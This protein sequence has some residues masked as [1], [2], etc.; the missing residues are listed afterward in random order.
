M[1]VSISKAAEMVGVTRAT[2]YRHIEKKGISLIKDDDGNPKVDVSELVRVYKHR[3]R[4]PEEGGLNT[5]DT[6]KIEHPVQ[7]NTPE[8]IQVEIGVLR[9][10]INGLETEKQLTE[11]ERNREREQL[12]EQIDALKMHLAN[13]QEQQK[14]LTLMLTDQRQSQEEGRGHQQDTLNDR[15]NELVS[16]LENQAMEKAA[17]EERIKALEHRLTEMKEKGD[18]IFRT[19]S[20]KNKRLFEQNKHLKE[21]VSKNLWTRL[22]G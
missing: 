15:M 21:E 2:F 11:N 22:F 17:Q 7:R 8:T 12:L 6:P 3:V 18:G 9:E 19:L 10:R 4:A 20:E 1:Q 5:L 13:S 16:R 14:R